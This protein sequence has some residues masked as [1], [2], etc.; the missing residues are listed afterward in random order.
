[1]QPRSGRRPTLLL[2]VLLSFLGGCGRQGAHPTSPD[3]PL[4]GLTSSGIGRPVPIGRAT[5]AV[6]W[7][8]YVPLVVGQEWHYQRTT[9]V[10]VTQG[11]GTLADEFD[12]SN[13]KDARLVGTV[14]IEG[15]EYVVEDD[16]IHTSDGG[17]EVRRF[18]WRQDS[19]GLY[20]AR[21]PGGTTLSPG[22][23]VPAA[24]GP[25]DFER[26]WSQLRARLSRSAAPRAVQPAR[27][28]MAAKVA[29]VE[30]AF[31]ERRPPAPG[32]DPPVAEIVRLRYPL[33]TG[34]EWVVRESPLMTARV[35]GSE[36]LTLPAGRFTGWRIRY[37]SE[38]LDP[39]DVVFIWYGRDGYLAL[40]AQLTGEA[41]DADG[42]P[43]GT[44]VTSISEQLGSSDPVPAT[45]DLRLTGSMTEI[46]TMTQGDCFYG[47]GNYPPDFFDNSDDVPS[48]LRARG[49][50]DVPGAATWWINW[51]I[52]PYTLGE[53][54]QSVTV[55]IRASAM[56]SNW[57]YPASASIRPCIDLVGY[58]APRWFTSNTGFSWSSWTFPNDPRTGRPW[59]ISD[60]N[61]SRFGFETHGA[62]YSKSPAD[63]TEVYFSEYR[64]T[65]HRVDGR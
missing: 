49:D 52:T 17:R 50:G 27:D 5:P 65:V 30:R 10:R 44:T 58:G 1:M 20:R 64:I 47:D 4:R 54:I 34:A 62:S 63:V 38:Q 23:A 28:R 48:M 37:T 2:L 46:P 43:V 35:E 57:N 42:N 51:P 11:D 6:G 53:P 13:R 25:T 55:Q 40:E 19:E 12:L 15:H 36:V 56:S 22:K 14:A 61:G 24:A 33:H 31:L 7:S 32:E 60:L 41:V 16:V 29:F 8:A 39:G 21:P 18:L 26:A 9:S 3:S 45:Q 59:E